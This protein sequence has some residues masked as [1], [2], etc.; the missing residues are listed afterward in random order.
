MPFVLLAVL[1]LIVIVVSIS[2][3]IGVAYP[4]LLLLAGMAVGFIPG[5]PAI[6]L[7][8]ELVLVIFLP[9]LLYWESV[10][11]PESEFRASAWWIFQLAFGLVIVTTVVVAAVTHAL[12]P[13]IGWAAA[14]VLGAAVSSTD[15]VAF[16][17][18][19]DRLPL[20]RHVVATIEGE[21]LVN[22]ATSLVLY[23][24]AIGAAVSGAFSL[25]QTVGALALSVAGGVALGVA[26]GFIAVQAWRFTPDPALQAVISIS[27][28]YLA[29]LPAHLIGAS[30]VLAVVVTG[31]FVNRFT[32]RVLTPS[33]RERAS[34]F[35]VTAVFVTNAV[36]FVLVGMQFHAIVT[37]LG[38][39]TVGAL[40]WY[41]VAVSATVIVLR[42]AW[43]FAQ[44]LLPI[45]NEPEHVEGKADWSHV[46]LLAWSGM[47]GG[48]TIAAALAIPLTAAGGPFPGRD[49]IIY[50]TFCVLL[51]TL[52]GQ[53]GTMPLLI[54]WLH[55]TADDVD[56]REERT[57]LA[58]T[59]SAAV[60]E[61]DRLAKTGDLP[62]GVVEQLRR[63]FKARMWEFGALDGDARKAARTNEL[64]RKTACAL[65]DAQRK[66]L[67][68]L[69][70]RGKIDNTVM[71]RIQRLLDLETEEVQLLGSAGGRSDLEAG[72]DE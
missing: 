14:F 33:A 7:P 49:L 64:Y 46:A 45:T 55:V 36:I 62:D 51:A 35:W 31:L 15:E 58:Q 48:I 20:P 18:I 69:R 72:E 67:I 43:V 60:A 5:F 70:D 25:M 44:G 30:G 2:N 3:R 11:A 24:V 42:L 68:D 38:H 56:A 40:I 29:Y 65:L 19:V 17:P 23:A 32:P 10:T 71:R 9:P 28:P 13:A 37:R 34:G 54:R 6:A 66:A 26:A 27:V 8:P 12:V 21:S 1:G 50:L 52:V 22:D 63:R 59:A 39:Y 41:G 57:A 61:L 47:R 16:A 53:G 4:I